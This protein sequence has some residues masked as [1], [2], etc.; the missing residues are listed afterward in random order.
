MR[1]WTG[2]EGQTPPDFVPLAGLLPGAANVWVLGC[3]RSG[4]TNG[5]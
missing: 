3:V 2:F 5:P 1:S 4:Y